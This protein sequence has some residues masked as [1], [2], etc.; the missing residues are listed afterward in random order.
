[1]FPGTGFMFGLVPI[2]VT[3]IFIVVI[4]S[5]IVIFIKGF[6]EWNRNN[7][8]PLLT[9]P[10]RVVAKR[11]N[12]SHH[13][14][15]HGS[16]MGAYHHSSSTTYYVTFGFESGDRL[17]LRVPHNEFG[18]LVEGDM[19]RLTFQGTRYKGFQRDI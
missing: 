1:M 9:V 17:E 5:F 19:G 15:H 18:Y 8:S 7:H 2:F 16:D 6:A 12:V 4:G 10:A 13:T 14:H 11:T 3:I